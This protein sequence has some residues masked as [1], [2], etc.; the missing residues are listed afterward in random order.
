MGGT[1][2]T[3][4]STWSIAGVPHASGSGLR[5]G[6]PAEEREAE[7]ATAPQGDDEHNAVGACDEIGVGAI[8]PLLIFIPM[9][10]AILFLAVVTLDSDYA[11]VALIP[12]FVLV[13]LCLA[14][15]GVGAGGSK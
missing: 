1:V 14:E 11:P 4:C 13:L 10:L 3:T 12:L 9:C 15:A 2:T 8:V 6:P 7:E 5:P